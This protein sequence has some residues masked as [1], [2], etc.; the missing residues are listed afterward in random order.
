[1]VPSLAYL[2][3]QSLDRDSRGGRSCP[4]DNTDKVTQLSNITHILFIKYV[5]HFLRTHQLELCHAELKQWPV[6]ITYEQV[7]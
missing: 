2:L 6:S 3:F 4:V 1:M 5:T 7:Y